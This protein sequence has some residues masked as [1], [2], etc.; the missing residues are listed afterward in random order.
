MADRIEIQCINKTNRP[1]PHERI[2]SVGGINPDRTPWKL[3]L[4]SI[5]LDWLRHGFNFLRIPRHS[6]RL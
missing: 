1:N 3:T 2:Q 5:I 6:Q 4:D